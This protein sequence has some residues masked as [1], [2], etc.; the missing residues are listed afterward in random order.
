MLCDYRRNI[1]GSSQA[2]DWTDMVTLKN[3]WYHFC[4]GWSASSD[5]MDFYV[6]GV[7][8]QTKATNLSSIGAGGTLVIGQDQDSLGGGFDKNQAFG[9]ELYQL[10]VFSRKLRVEEI[11]AMYFNGRCSSLPSTLVHDVVVSWE[12]ILGATR[13]GAVQEVSAEC[14]ERNFLGKVTQLVLEEVNSCRGH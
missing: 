1:I 2:M 10:N 3:E 4:V 11:A 5:R 14:S 8:V 6:N 13:F 9:G 12:D 7:L